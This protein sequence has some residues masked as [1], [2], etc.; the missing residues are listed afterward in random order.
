MA[1]YT[2]TSGCGHTTRIN[3]AG[4][5]RERERRIDWMRS[6]TGRCNPCY[7][8]M[9]RDEEHT[10]DE[11]EAKRM[12]EQ[13]RVAQPDGDY[14]TKLL[15]LETEALEELLLKADR[16]KMRRARL[17]LRAIEIVGRENLAGK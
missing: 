15:K 12:A 3:L 1:Q 11:I 2:I 5:H 16:L 14:A 10:R 4:P 8:A 17:V 9:K 7:A 6:P 13:L